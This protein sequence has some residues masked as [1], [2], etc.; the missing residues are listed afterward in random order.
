MHCL[1]VGL[2][3][4]LLTP[5][6]LRAGGAS[7]HFAHWGENL[8]RLAW[9]GR[10]RSMK[11]L[12]HYVQ[13]LA[14]ATVWKHI[15]PDCRKLVLLLSGRFAQACTTV[16]SK[17]AKAV[18]EAMDNVTVVVSTIAARLLRYFPPLRT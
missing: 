8:P 1:A 17:R 6:C 12:E 14:V 7:F 16:P 11:M 3:A 13:E 4:K 9:R 15:T 18:M 2:P 10:W 5:S